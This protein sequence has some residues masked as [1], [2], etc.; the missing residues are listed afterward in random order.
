MGE[1]FLSHCLHLRVRL[2]EQDFGAGYFSIDL[3]EALV[4]FD[5]LAQIGVML[6][7]SAIKDSVLDNLRFGDLF[8]QLGEFALD[9]FAPR[10][11]GG[12]QRKLRS[13]VPGADRPLGVRLLRLVS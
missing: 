6:G 8:V 12:V 1:L 13:A 10:D 4:G 9:I 7:E 2:I 11:D 3:L 5:N